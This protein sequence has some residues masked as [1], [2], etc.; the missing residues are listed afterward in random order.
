M[1]LVIERGVNHIDVGPRMARLKNGS[2]HGMKRDASAFSS[3]A[4]L[5]NDRKGR[6]GRT[7]AFLQR[8]QVTHF[9]LLPDPSITT[10]TELD[11][12]TG[13]AARWT[14]SAR[15]SVTV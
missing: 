9:D 5:P 2:D 6:S 8:L 13:Q 3:A 10:M 7:Q 11:Q 1:R 4:R 12:V 14:P 15:R